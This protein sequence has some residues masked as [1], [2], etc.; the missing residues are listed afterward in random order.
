MSG[1]DEVAVLEV[2]ERAADQMRRENRGTWRQRIEALWPAIP[3]R[4]W[5]IEFGADHYAERLVW[6][7]VRLIRCDRQVRPR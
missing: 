1:L 4:G 2:G 3:Q 7:G 5:L 6:G